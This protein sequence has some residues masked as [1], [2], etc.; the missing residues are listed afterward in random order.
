[1]SRVAV[2]ACDYSAYYVSTHSYCASIGHRNHYQQF[3]GDQLPRYLQR[4][5]S[6]EYAGHIDGD[7][8]HELFLRRL[9]RELHWHQRLHHY[10]CSRRQR[11]RNVQRRGR[12]D[13]CPGGNGHRH[14]HEFHGRD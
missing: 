7:S 5:L 6:R 14:G 2:G 13:R 12:I 11:Q 9:E 3:G 10:S 8:G 4:E 1:M